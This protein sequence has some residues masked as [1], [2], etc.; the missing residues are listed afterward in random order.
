METQLTT[1]RQFARAWKRLAK[2]LNNANKV[3]SKDPTQQE[4]DRLV[5]MHCFDAERADRAESE[6]TRLTEENERLRR[7]NERLKDRLRQA[8]RIIDVQKK[9]SEMLNI[10]RKHENDGNA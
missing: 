2:I 9:L 4:W 8:E 7:E 6:I 10:P 3:L 5:G 1:A